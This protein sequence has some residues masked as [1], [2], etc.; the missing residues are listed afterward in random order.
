MPIRREIEPFVADAIGWRRD[1]HAHPELMYDLPRTSRFVADLLQDFGCDEVVTS[2]GRSGVVGM[3]KGA[4]PGSRKVIGLRADMDA[5]PIHEET[6]LTYRSSI[7]GKMHACGHDGHTAMLL[8]AARYLAATRNFSGTVIVIF[9]PAEEGGAG[10]KAMIDDGLMERFGIQE[11]YGLHNLPNLPIGEIAMRPGPIMAAAD[12]FIIHIEGKGGH[13]AIPDMCRDPVLAGAAIVT[14]LQSIVARSL[15][16]IDS[17]VVSATRFQ[18]GTAFNI[19]PQTAEIMGTT[20]SFTREVQDLIE[21]RMDEIVRGVAVSHGVK[22]SLTY[23]RN[24]PSTINHAPQTAFAASVAKKLLGEKNVDTDAPPL[25]GAE[26]FSFMLQSRPG[27]YIFLGNGDTAGL[28]HPAYD[29]N[30]AALPVGMSYW[31]E[32][33]ETA[34]QA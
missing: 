29:F 24:Y 1:L 6:N 9:Q 4:K 12:H 2:I 32:L 30:D 26:D 21:Q 25:L 18:A 7:A 33:A 11:V 5:L 16:P 20:R 3:I 15:R 8:G 34:L 14:A 23:N 13:G 10:A 19:I 31:T 22:A 28:H 17:A 27:A